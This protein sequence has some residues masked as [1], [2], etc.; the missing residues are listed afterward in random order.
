VASTG[1]MSAFVGFADV[2]TPCSGPVLFTY[3]AQS[4]REVPRANVK[5]WGATSLKLA[6]PCA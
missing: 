1:K 6:A 4:F 2:G 3:R 5:L